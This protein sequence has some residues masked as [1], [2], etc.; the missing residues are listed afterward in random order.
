MGVGHVSNPTQARLPESNSMAN[1]ATVVSGYGSGTPIA[2]R[3]KLC[4]V[5]RLSKLLFHTFL[6]GDPRWNCNITREE[7]LGKRALDLV[8]GLGLMGLTVFG[9]SRL[10]PTGLLKLKL[11]LLIS[12]EQLSF[13]AELSPAQALQ[14][15]SGR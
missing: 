2:A 7:L 4:G 14:R 5:G 10:L 3:C 9:Q 15:R 8:E 13:L 1:A 11:D 6:H 12:K